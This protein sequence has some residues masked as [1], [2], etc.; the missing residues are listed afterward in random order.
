MQGWLPWVEF[1]LESMRVKVSKILLTVKVGSKGEV[2]S[3]IGHETTEGS[4]A[5]VLNPGLTDPPSVVRL[6]EGFH[7]FGWRKKL[8]LYFHKPL[9]EIKHL[10]Q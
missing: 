6:R 2:R 5:A 10:I 4:R 9:T 1:V 8:Q 7:E 3:I